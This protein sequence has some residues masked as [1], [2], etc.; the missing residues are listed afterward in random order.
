[1]SLSSLHNRAKYATQMSTYVC[2]KRMFSKNVRPVFDKT[3]W[4]WIHHEEPQVDFGTLFGDDN[5]RR[6]LINADHV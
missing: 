1:M 5:D 6:F 4:S 3:S 2:I